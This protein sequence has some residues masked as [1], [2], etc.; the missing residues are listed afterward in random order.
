M[1]SD[2]L[3]SPDLT[4]VTD[5]ISDQFVLAHLR[6]LATLFLVISPQLLPSFKIYSFRIQDMRVIKTVSARLGGIHVLALVTHNTHPSTLVRSVFGVR[7]MGVVFAGCPTGKWTH[8]GY[9]MQ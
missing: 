6:R 2:A 1:I 5:Y 4:L 7:I 8:P 9:M 3:A